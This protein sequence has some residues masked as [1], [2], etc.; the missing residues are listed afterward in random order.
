MLL[1]GNHYFYKNQRRII[2]FKIKE[3][4]RNKMK[5]KVVGISTL[6]DDM[7]VLFVEKKRPEADWRCDRREGVAK[8][9]HLT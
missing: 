3:Q 5:H 4:P 2:I 7:H 1:F 6:A 8:Y 9:A